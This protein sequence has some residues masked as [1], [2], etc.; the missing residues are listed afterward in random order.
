MSNV[1]PFRRTSESLMM[2]LA[3]Q[4]MRGLRIQTAIFTTA[5]SVIAS[6]AFGV[7]VCQW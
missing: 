2:E 1:T 4:K 7:W 6:F 3:E 5:L